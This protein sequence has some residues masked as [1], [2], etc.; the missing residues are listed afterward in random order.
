MAISIPEHQAIAV[1]KHAP[2][3]DQYDGAI[4]VTVDIDVYRPHRIL[5]NQFPIWETLDQLRELKNK[6]FEASLLPRTKEI[7]K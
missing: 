6:I 3:K 5:V 2:A 1:L 4:A 7:F